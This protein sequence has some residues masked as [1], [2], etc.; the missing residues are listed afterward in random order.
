MTTV[1][2]ICDTDTGLCAVPGAG[3]EQA[4]APDVAAVAQ[5]RPVRITYVTDPICSACWVSEPAW[6]SVTSRYADVLDVEH[7]YGGLLPSWDGFLDAGAGIRQPSDVA[8]HWDEFSTMTGQPIDAS[9]WLTDPLHSSFPASIA[10]VAVR[11]V[12]PALETEFLR[13]VRELLFLDARN[14]ARP[15]VLAEAAVAIGVDVAAYTAALADGSAE[16]QFLQDRVRSRTLGVRG[17]PTLFVEGVGGRLV[18][19]GIFGPEQLERAVL[20]VSGL[21]RRPHLPGVDAAADQLGLGTSAEYAAA[22]GW[23]TVATERALAAAGMHKT[24]IGGGAVWRK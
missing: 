12:A 10:A 15:E 14:I 6:R 20:A 11:L 2:G 3:A 19:H 23:D 13:R 22:L 9:V 17:F 8:H 7:V 4:A 1:A 18:V 24:G 5:E 16:A 21:E